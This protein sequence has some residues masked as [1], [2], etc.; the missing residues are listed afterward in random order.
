M[1][2]STTKILPINND[3]LN[4][5]AQKNKPE[6]EEDLS[7]EAKEWLEMV[8]PSV[9][10]DQGFPMEDICNSAYYEYK[11]DAT[12]VG[13]DGG[14]DE[15]AFIN[16]WKGTF[17]TRYAGMG[18]GFLIS[19]QD[20]GKIELATNKYIKKDNKGRYVFELVIKDVDLKQDY[21]ITIKLEA[22]GKAFLIS[23]VLQPIMD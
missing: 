15:Q 8:I 11:S 1:N 13:Y 5:E 2:T 6:E 23:D 22:V 10:N 16:K 12:E 4:I 18:V 19:G 21:P 9:F 7:E 20:Y 3:S 17:D 14:L